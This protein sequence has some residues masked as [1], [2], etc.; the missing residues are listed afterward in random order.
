MVVEEMVAAAR[1]VRYL[2]ERPRRSPNPSLSS[3]SAAVTR[4]AHSR[5][6]AWLGLARVQC[7]G[8]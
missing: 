7:V 5:E 1:E 3:P 2:W 8:Q 4:M 6:K